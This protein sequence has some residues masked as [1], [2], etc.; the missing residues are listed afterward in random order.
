MLRLFAITHMKILVASTFHRPG[1]KSC[2]LPLSSGNIY[3]GV[4]NVGTSESWSPGE[5]VR[6]YKA[7]RAMAGTAEYYASAAP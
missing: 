1:P 4:S 5:C 3:S 2:P 6:S 7:R